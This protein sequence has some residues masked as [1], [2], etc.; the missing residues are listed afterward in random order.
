[1]SRERTFRTEAIVMRRTDFGEADRLL[2]LFSRERGKIKAIAKGARKPQSRKTGHVD[3]FMRSNFFIAVGRSLDIVTQA[4]TVAAHAPLRQDLERAT[5]AAYLVEL[6]DRFIGEEDPHAGVYQL[7]ADALLWLTEGETADFYLIA[8]FYELRLLALTG[9]Q[10]QL[11]NCVACSNPIQE[12]DQFFS[13]ELGG[14]LCPNCRQSDRNARPVTAV[15]VKVLRY[16][17]TRPWDTVKVLQLKRPLHNELEALMHHYL[18]FTL[19]RNL[20]SVDFLHRL[21]S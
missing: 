12:Q 9:F 16:L 19:E 18:I 7:L 5:Y 8:R 3:L 20:K 11:F 15:A 1:M 2:T 17:Q 14:L 4:E 21:R 10:P 13:A 6:L